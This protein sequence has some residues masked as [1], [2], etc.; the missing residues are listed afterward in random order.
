MLKHRSETPVP[1]VLSL[2]CNL[3]Q[4]PPGILPK[5]NTARQAASAEPATVSHV[6]QPP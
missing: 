3:G 5:G 1:T 4:E 2:S 6:A